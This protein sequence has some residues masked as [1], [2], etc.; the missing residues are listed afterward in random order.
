MDIPK[1]TVTSPRL[2]DWQWI[3]LRLGL[4]A[5]AVLVLGVVAGIKSHNSAVTS[6]ALL[7]A[8]AAMVVAATIEVPLINNACARRRRKALQSSPAGTLLAVDGSQIG[9]LAGAAS[10][11]PA[12][13]RACGRAASPSAKSV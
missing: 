13:A 6:G 10:G 12:P 3:A 1:I 4:P 7:A 8:G 2:R 5:G 9:Y 11:L